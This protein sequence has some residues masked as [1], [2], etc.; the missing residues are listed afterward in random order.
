MHFIIS[1]CD[2]NHAAAV[3]ARRYMLDPDHAPDHA[4]DPDASPNHAVAPT[5][6][7]GPDNPYFTG[8]GRM[9]ASYAFEFGYVR[10][11]NPMLLSSHRSAV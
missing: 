9:R 5:G 2:A 8:S 4:D 7:V 1:F 3:Y 10:I 11:S 6:E